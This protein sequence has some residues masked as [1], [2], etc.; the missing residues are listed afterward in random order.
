MRR[1]RVEIRNPRSEGKIKKMFCSLEEDEDGT[2]VLVSKG[3][4]VNAS[5]DVVDF[6]KQVPN[7]YLEQAIKR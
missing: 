4:N 5:I 3:K 2:A 7:K 6:L 1:K